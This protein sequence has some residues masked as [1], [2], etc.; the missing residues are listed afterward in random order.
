MGSK[1]DSRRSL[2]Y[3]VA[4][5]GHFNLV[6]MALQWNKPT[7]HVLDISLREAARHG[8]AKVVDHL[9]KQGARTEA[10]DDIE[11]AI[12]FSAARHA[13]VISILLERRANIDARISNRQNQTVLHHYAIV[14]DIDG[15][16][17]LLNFGCHIEATDAEGNNA[18]H[19]AATNSRNDVAHLL[20]ARGMDP[21]A[22]KRNGDAALH[23]A[24]TTDNLQL[25][26][27][28]INYGV[29]IESKD[30]V[31]NTALYIAS[32]R[33]NLQMFVSFL[34]KVPVSIQDVPLGGLLCM[35][36]SL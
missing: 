18:L 24:A 19:Y 7:Q 8:Y 25:V 27:I 1:N 4:K 28:R 34:Q 13:D 15:V 9:L 32:L 31:K 20:L 22:Q 21:N 2:V 14:G 35:Q 17:I 26:N 23:I 16:Y 30:R 11:G 12:L 6:E 5:A 36:Q 10:S 33:N 29:N 3:V